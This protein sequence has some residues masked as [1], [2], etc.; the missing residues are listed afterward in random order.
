MNIMP[1]RHDISGP[2]ESHAKQKRNDT[3]QI[4]EEVSHV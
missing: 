1:E 3:I 4:E 2:N